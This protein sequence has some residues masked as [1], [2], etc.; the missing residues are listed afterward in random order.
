MANAKHAAGVNA[1]LFK[2]LA[3]PVRGR[4]LVILDE[5]PASPT[6]L[7]ELLDEPFHNVAYHVRELAKADDEGLSLIELVATDSKRGGTQ[8]IYKATARPILHVEAWE[9]LSQL[10]REINSTWVGQIMIGDM[11]EAMEART[12]DGR[13]GRTMLRMNIVVDEQGW[14]DL[15]PAAVAYLDRLHEIA[16]ESSERLAGGEGIRVSTHALAFEAAPVSGT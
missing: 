7:A 13:P 5:R 4:I 9:K 6:E 12:F 2:A 11:I 3:H 1:A 15:E 14:D 16:S 10:M 8:H